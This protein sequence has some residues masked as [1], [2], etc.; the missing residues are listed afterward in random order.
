MLKHYPAADA[1]RSLMAP[2]P[3]PR[4]TLTPILDAVGDAPETDSAAA[5]FEGQR[6]RMM[7]A[8]IIQAWVATPADDLD[9]DET[10]ADRLFALVL[11]EIDADIDGDITDEQ[12]EAANEVLDAAAD[13][14][15]AKGVPEDDCD[16]LLN[17]FDAAA[18]DRVRDLLAETLPSD[19]DEALADIDSFAFDD[20]AEQSVFD[21]AGNVVL[22]A[23]YKK[24]VV[25]R[26]GKR[27]RM[28][29]R[30]SGRVRLTAKQKIAVR[31]MQRRSHTAKA[32]M[33]RMKSMRIRRQ[34]NL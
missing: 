24:K 18:A 14:L 10:M 34:M 16:A 32:K 15:V 4:K 1:L 19:D 23:V 28:R 27:M 20:E 5:V 9:E 3:E 17:D 2:P 13:Y 26:K 25:I 12:A 31:K 7:A 22:D 21:D 6:T 33:Q 8:S 11:G 29:K 30:V